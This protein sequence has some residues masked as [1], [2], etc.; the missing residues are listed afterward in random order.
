[1][2]ILIVKLSSIGDIVH[3]LPALAG[4]RTAFPGAKIGWAVEC[5]S[6]E[7]IRGNPLIDELIEL[8]TR[9][10]RNNR[11]IEE[12]LIDAGR[13]ITEL[14]KYEFDISIDFQG[15]VKS[16]LVGKFTRAGSRFG[17]SKSGLRE[18]AARFL[19]TETID[20][21]PEI[22]VIEKNLRL[23]ERSLGIEIGRAELQF[24]ISTG[25]SHRGEAEAL[26]AGAGRPFAILNP[27]GG[28]PTKLWEAERFGEL[29]VRLDRELGLRSVIVT[30]P[31]ESDLAERAAAHAG[32]S[33]PLTASPTLKGLYEL[34]RRAAVY[35]GGDTGPTHLAV[36]A[37]CPVVGIFGPTEW[38]RN[39]SP[40][41]DD[42]CVERVD[43]DCRVDCH[44][45][46]CSNWICMEI[47]VDQ[48]FNAVFKRLSTVNS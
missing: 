19:L 22:H 31:N 24:P 12:L 20:L 38:W 6:A 18:P 36:A 15:L 39:G 3:T 26:V 14:R 8:D 23:A 11:R 2:K 47:S 1:M 42:L 40:F 21:P 46:S 27:A 10:L 32:D 43:I 44:R 13:Q 16:A 5:S 34:A 17:F 25:S 29:A 35:V 48:V 37:R 4:I 45:R 33:T 7:I 9:S 30:G 41:P 28:W